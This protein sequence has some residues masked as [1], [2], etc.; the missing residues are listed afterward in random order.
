MYLETVPLSASMR[1]DVVTR[2]LARQRT[3][4]AIVG[5]VRG[6][7]EQVARFR[8]GTTAKGERK[9]TDFVVNII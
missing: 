3:A 8:A 6:R 4:L 1:P 2:E 5:T 7:G 9:E